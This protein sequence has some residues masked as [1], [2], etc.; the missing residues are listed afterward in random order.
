MDGWIVG[1]MDKRMDGWINDQRGLKVPLCPNKKIQVTKFEPHQ[2][3]RV[4]RGKARELLQVWTGEF[5]SVN[6][7]GN[8]QP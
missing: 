7:R 3:L 6:T 4:A 5:V 8:T 2:L 1:W